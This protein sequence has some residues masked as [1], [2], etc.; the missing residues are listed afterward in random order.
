MINISK[1]YFHD[2]KCEEIERELH[3]HP[4]FDGWT[5]KRFGSTGGLFDFEDSFEI[6]DRKGKRIEVYSESEL[7]FSLAMGTLERGLQTSYRMGFFRNFSPRSICVFIFIIIGIPLIVMIP[8]LNYITSLPP[9]Q[10]S[11][12]FFLMFFVLGGLMCIIYI[13]Q[14]RQNNK[15][16]EIN[17]EPD[18]PVHERKKL[19]ME[20]FGQVDN[21]GRMKKE[22]PQLY[23]QKLKEL[24][25]KITIAK[26]DEGSSFS[27]L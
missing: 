8:L 5:V 2:S 24:T 23:I 12:S 7:D 3:K 10:A 26:E 16:G 9:D 20:A 15:L 11:L 27:H 17:N 14:N 1:Q 25:E 6:L 22:D 18:I 21:I 13:S 19:M 4:F